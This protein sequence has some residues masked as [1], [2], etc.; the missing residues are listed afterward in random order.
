MSVNKLYEEVMSSTDVRISLHE[1]DVI[2]RIDKISQDLFFG[3]VLKIDFYQMK[4]TL[5]RAAYL[6]PK[7]GRLIF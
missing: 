6:S 3:I 7:N 1:I 2:I 4:K 5:K